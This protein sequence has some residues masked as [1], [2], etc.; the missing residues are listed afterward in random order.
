[1]KK[2]IKDFIDKNMGKGLIQMVISKSRIKD[3]PSKVKIRPILLKDKFIYQATETVGP[4]V[5]H[6]NYERQELIEYIGELMEERFMQL[7]WEGQ[8]EDGLVLVSKKGHLTTKVKRHACKKEQAALEHNRRKKYLL[9]EGTAVPFLVDLG[10]MTPQGKIVS[11]KYD[12]F[13]QINRFLEF[14]E[15]IL[16][17]L[18]RGRELTILD[19][20]CGKSYLTFAMYYY[21]RQLRHFDVRIIGLDLKEDVIQHCNELAQSYGYEKLKFY[22]GDIASYEGVRQVDMVVTL[23]ACDTATDYALAKAVYWGAKVILS[24]PCCQHEL[25]GQIR[26]EMLSPVLSYGILKERMA[27][28]ITDGLR[29]QLLEGVGY[30]TQ[31][32]EFVDMEHTPKNLLIRGVYTGKKKN[33]EKTRRC[34]EELHLN[35]TLARLLEE[36]EVDDQ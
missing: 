9:A 25:N 12:K 3:G 15:D 29:A 33:L 24:V 14:I 20:G 22:T 11:T 34:I 19:F 35:P 23:H 27:A 28:L 8:Y 1:M 31:I 7:Q 21:L 2:E 26:N 16:P 36:Q 17:R 32:L 30:E 5:L 4:K 6:T 18:D 10:V 13:R